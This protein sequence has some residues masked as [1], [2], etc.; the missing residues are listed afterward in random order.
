M[1]CEIFQNGDCGFLNVNWIG[2]STNT[3]V[4]RFGPGVRNHYIIHFVFSGKGYFNGQPVSTG[5][6]FLI[7][8]GMQEEYHSDPNEPW[9]FLW[10]L[11]E[12]PKMKEVFDL[13]E[14][15]ENNIFYYD[16]IHKIKR[17]HAFL[18]ANRSKTYSSYEMLEFFFSII[19][20]QQ[21]NKSKRSTASNAAVYVESA[22]KYI[23]SNIS[24]PI[25]ISD[26]TV[27][28][29]V[30]QPYLYKIFIEH[31]AMSPKEYILSEKLLNA[32]LLLEKTDI[33]ITHIANSVGFQDSLMFSKFFKNKTG[34]SPTNWRK[35]SRFNFK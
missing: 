31:T 30:S 6:G 17:V 10:I 3:D 35:Q 22:K 19:K 20:H 2:S 18:E 26:I 11:S 16:Y 13:F 25:T 23:S 12:D 33:S 4:T 9:G 8:P 34:V 15:D 7:T 14:I 32:Q 1:H 28:L 29:G 27:F 5:Q 21:T 24:K